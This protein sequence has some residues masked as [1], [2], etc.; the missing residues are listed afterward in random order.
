MM[1]TM[2]L[3]AALLSFAGCEHYCVFPDKSTS[4]AVCL[5]LMLKGTCQPAKEKD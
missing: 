1:R 2:I 3:L 4:D 5:G